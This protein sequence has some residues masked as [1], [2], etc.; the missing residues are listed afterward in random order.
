M[1][2]DHRQT[3]AQYMAIDAVI[4]SIHHFTDMVMKANA[5]GQQIDSRIQCGVVNDGSDDQGWEKR[6]FDGSATF[7]I[8]ISANPKA[9]QPV[10]SAELVDS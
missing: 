8:V 9:K 1:E 6:R 2:M 10:L 3:K 5:N 4:D 7:T